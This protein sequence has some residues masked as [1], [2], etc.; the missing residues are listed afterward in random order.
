MQSESARQVEA[1]RI[2]RDKVSE[3]TEELRI[4]EELHTHLQAEY[5]KVS[6]DISRYLKLPFRC[7]IIVLKEESSQYF[8]FMFQISI[9]QKNHGNHWKYQ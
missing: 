5:A 2:T 3:L 9:H 1:L 7:F 6:K 8:R 4:K